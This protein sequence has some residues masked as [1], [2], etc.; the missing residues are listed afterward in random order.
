MSI[1]QAVILGTD[2]PAEH[3]AY[4]Q[5]REVV[6]SHEV[7]PHAGFRRTIH[8][9]IDRGRR[10]ACEIRDRV[11]VVDQP[12]LGVRETGLHGLSLLDSNDEQAL[13][14]S[15]RQHPPQDGIH[16]REDRRVGP[17][18]QRERQRDRRGEAGRLSKHA[19]RVAHVLDDR[20]EEPHAPRVTGL[21]L[22]LLDSA[23]RQSRSTLGL[24]R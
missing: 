4:S 3:G 19:E 24:G 8:T 5:E 23:H 22:H 11:V 15:H 20:F 17:D 14:L 7:C 16:Q 13:R 12:E 6:A 18:A 2:R 10:I 9:D 21:F 1:R